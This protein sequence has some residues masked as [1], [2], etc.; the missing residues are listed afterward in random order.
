MASILSTPI[1]LKFLR[2]GR[3]KRLCMRLAPS[4]WGFFAL[5][6]CGFL[7]SINFSNNLIFAMT[8][9]L[10]GV[11]LVGWYF[12]RVNLSGVVP[13]DWQVESVFAGQMAVYRLQAENRS[14]QDR[15]G[16]RVAAKG[17]ESEGEHLLVQGGRVEMVLRRSAQKR[18]TL[19]RSAA[20][21][22][23]AFPLGLFEARLSAGELPQCLVYPKPVGAQP[24]PEHQPNRSAHQ[25]KESGAYTD[26]RRYAPGDPLSRISWRALAR[27]DKLYTKEFDGAQGQSALWLRWD[28]LWVSAVEDRLSQLSR[29][30]LDAHRLGREYGLELPGTRLAPSSEEKHLRACLKALAL[31]GLGETNKEQAA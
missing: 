4:G 24:L 2:T 5:I 23:S 10:I 9:L 16:L 29:W 3:Q 6:G 7:L 17:A 20:T 31:Y 15:Y 22:R 28:D 19:P 30:V 8:F 12:T 21:I 27:F 18:G 11:A 14:G 26:M 1:A 25:L 13:A